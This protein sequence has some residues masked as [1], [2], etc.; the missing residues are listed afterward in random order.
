[1]QFAGEREV[2]LDFDLDNMER[3]RRTLESLNQ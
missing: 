3:D 1:M 2:E